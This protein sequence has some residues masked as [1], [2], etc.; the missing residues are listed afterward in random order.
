MSR[1]KLIEQFCLIQLQVLSDRESRLRKELQDCRIQREYLSHFL[2]EFEE[3][4][5]FEQLHTF[6]K[7]IKIIEEE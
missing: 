5:K 3:Y 1:P 7:E 2:M 4:E 6:I